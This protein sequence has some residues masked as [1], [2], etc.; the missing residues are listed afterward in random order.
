ME[1]SPAGAD[2]WGKSHEISLNL[3]KADRKASSIYVQCS[4]YLLPDNKSPERVSQEFRQGL[5]ERFCSTK[6]PPRLFTSIQLADGLVWRV[7]DGFT[8]MSG[9]LVDMARRLGLMGTVDQRTY[10]YM[11]CPAWWPQGSWTSYTAA[12]CSK[13]KCTVNNLEATWFFMTW[14]W[15]H[16][17]S[18][19]L[20]CLSKWSRAQ[21]DSRGRDLDPTSQW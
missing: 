8:H 11:V 17:E 15:N 16:T 7:C 1:L 12:Q 3:L 19:L 20:C 4:S 10:P 6:H 9:T 18:L 14:L 21:P 5:A 13:N 2:G